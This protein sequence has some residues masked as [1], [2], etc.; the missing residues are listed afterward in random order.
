MIHEVFFTDLFGKKQIIDKFYPLLN[1]K[2]RAE[3]SIS[4]QHKRKVLQL[5]RDEVESFKPK[6]NR[7]ISG[8]LSVKSAIS[9]GTSLHKDH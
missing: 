3:R 5:E 9:R 8:K 7:P 1:N 6:I 4:I 2:K